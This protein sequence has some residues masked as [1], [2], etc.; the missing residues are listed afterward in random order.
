MVVLESYL[1]DMVPERRGSGQRAGERAMCRRGAE[2]RPAGR[3]G[4]YRLSH[5]C[6]AASEMA[7]RGYGTAAAT[8]GEGGGARGPGRRAAL[9]GG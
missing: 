7:E 6:T 2:V 1:R 4:R 9:L 5:T 8:A 3:T